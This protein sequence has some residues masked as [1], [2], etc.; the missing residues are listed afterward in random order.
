[1]QKKILVILCK[2]LLAITNP[3]NRLSNKGSVLME[4]LC[5]F[6]SLFLF[7]KGLFFI[8]YM[9]FIHLMV[10]YHLYEAS[11]CALGHSQKLEICRHHYQKKLKP[12]LFWVRLQE[13][14]LQAK[15][16]HLCGKG[17]FSFP[18]FKARNK[19]KVGKTPFFS[20]P[21][22]FR[23][24]ESFGAKTLMSLIVKRF[25]RSPQRKERERGFVALLFCFCLPLLMG[26][27][28]F[29]FS[30]SLLLKLRMQA[31]HLCR[32]HNLKAQ[33]S[34][35][36][37]LTKLFL[38]NPHSLRLEKRR[39]ALQIRLALSIS[40]GNVAG[41]VRT[42]LLLSKLRKA[43]MALATRQQ[44]FL[45]KAKEEANRILFHLKNS[46]FLDLKKSLNLSSLFLKLR[47]ITLKWEQVPLA[48]YPN[49]LI[50]IA[51]T[52]H[53]KALFSDEQKIKISW[54]FLL[55]F[56]FLGQKKS[57]TVQDS[58][59]ASIQKIKGGSQWIAHLRESING[60]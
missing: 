3:L 42:Q 37:N 9:V 1:M 13:F 23:I 26:T 22:I 27:L 52:Y 48:I 6:L 18:I 40:K 45:L 32:T 21:L 33:R 12:F 58:C 10:N 46:F 17:S 41:I 28:V 57:W 38:L 19:N 43:K 11:L 25:P 39:K 34:I 20:S 56:R 29:F 47:P 49:M 2:G 7:L 8:F 16:Q 30:S 31:Q 15:P 60:S 55:H 24:F 50:P 59:V 5:V 36:K 51:P 4:S 35:L 14:H 54:S 44:N 53:R